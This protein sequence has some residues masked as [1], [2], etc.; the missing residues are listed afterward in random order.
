MRSKPEVRRNRK[1]EDYV[2]LENND[3][4][5]DGAFE[6]YKFYDLMFYPTIHSVSNFRPVIELF[7]LFESRSVAK[8]GGRGP[9]RGM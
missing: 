3:G 4:T 5:V 9:V 7:R 2:L 1:I 6:L 8:L